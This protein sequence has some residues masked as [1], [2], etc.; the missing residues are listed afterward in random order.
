MKKNLVLTLLAPMMCLSLV[1]CHSNVGM[2]LTYGTYISTT[3]ESKNDATKINYSELSARMSSDGAYHNENFLLTVAPTNGCICWAKFQ[4][5]LKQ[6]IKET[7]YLVYQINCDEFGENSNFGLTFQDGH[8]TFAIIKGGNIVKQYMSS[9]VLDSKDALKSEVDKFVRAPE[10]YYV[11]EPFLNEAIKTGETT[12]VEYIRN[13]CSDCNY[14]NPNIL[15]TFAHQNVFATKMYVID[16]QD[17]WETR[18]DSTDYQNFKD[19][20]LLSKAF[21]ENYGYDNGYVPTFQYYQ[22]GKI[23]SAS[24]TFN[25]E[26]AKV[27]DEYK[28]VNSYYTQERLPNLEYAQNVSTNVLKGLTLAEEDVLAFNGEYYWNQNKAVEYHKPLFEAFLKTYTK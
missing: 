18:N 11:D 4:A 13:G 21:D 28:V 1:G 20:Y 10:L 5:V 14:V 26:I 3:D 25:D 24:V 23:K 6:F 19:R 2:K 8:V 9:S 22:R 16:L 27:N 12:L 7:H 15:W 17:L